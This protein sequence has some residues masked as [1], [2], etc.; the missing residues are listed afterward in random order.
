MGLQPVQF[1]AR[2]AVRMPYSPAKGCQRFELLPP[3]PVED[4]RSLVAE[5]NIQSPLQIYQET[6]KGYVDG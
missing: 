6:R 3:S 5:E 4:S 1:H 2:S